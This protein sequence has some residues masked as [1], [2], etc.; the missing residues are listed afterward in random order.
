M[1]I[2][3]SAAI[4]PISD[5]LQRRMRQHPFLQQ[6]QGEMG[7][8]NEDDKKYRAFQQ[9]EQGDRKSAQAKQG[10]K[11]VMVCALMPTAP[12]AVA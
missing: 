2:L 7:D 6:Q 9:K 10:L 8:Q 5:G 3:S 1:W 4:A 11:Q 12:K